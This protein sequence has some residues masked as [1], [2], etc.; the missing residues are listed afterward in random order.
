ML[1]GVPGLKKASF[2]IA[3][4]IAAS[5]GLTSCGSYRSP[6][7]STQRRSGL[8]FRAFVSNPLQPS[9]FGPAPVLNIVDA[10][11]DVLSLFTI[12]LASSSPQPR[13]M[14]VS[15]NRN[16]TLVFSASNNSITV[17]NNAQEAS[18]SSINLPAFTESLF[19]WIDNLT[20]YAAVPNAPAGQSLGAVEQL[21]LSAGVISATLPIRNAHFIVQSHSGNRILAFGDN[22]DTVTV[23]A[24]SL[25]GTS[26]APRTFVCP[27]GTP[28]PDVTLCNP[29]PANKVFDDPVQE[30][31]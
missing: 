18:V 9:A 17:V 1:F 22:S 30:I 3:A 10:S 2:A 4:L 16:F 21:N 28:E 27:D 23:I 11:K 20:A 26:Q 7:S 31:C 19:V 13:L 5:I 12:S 25:I 14:A 15:P 24:P 6:S 29:N 8:K